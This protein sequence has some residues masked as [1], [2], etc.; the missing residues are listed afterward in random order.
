[1]KLVCH[2]CQRE[3]EPERIYCHDCGARLDRSALAKVK[4]TAEDPRETHRRLAKMFDP[5]RAAMRQRFFQGSKLILAA[6]AAAV[7]I[8]IVR[9]AEMPER[10]KTTSML[11]SQI[12]LDLENAALDPRVPPLRYSDEQVN[13]YLAY[14]LKGKKA[15]LSKYLQFERAVVAFEEGYFHVTVE[16]SLFG[17][18]L[19]TSASYAP[20][21]QPGKLEMT[22][23]GGH[24]GRM[25]IHPALMQY[26]DVVFKDVAGALERERKSVIKLGSV[27]LHPKLVVLTP[28]TPA[29]PAAQPVP[30]PQPAATQTAMP[31]PAQP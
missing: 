30:Q 11:P 26:V 16:R 10:P 3:N 18:S 2:E 28:R 9:P 13:A 8:Q 22:N 17:Y 23:R 25:P 24:L 7:I 12:N 20:K 15:A 1:M 19:Y 21:L 27:E 29:A 6:L 31:T 14:V 5:G 4:S